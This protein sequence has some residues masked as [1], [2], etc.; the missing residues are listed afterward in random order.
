MAMLVGVLMIHGVQPGPLMM[1]KTPELFWGV[2]TSMY[3]GNF[4]LLVLNL[5][6]I[7]LWVR[8]LLIPY[9]ILFPLILMFC[10]IG[11]YSLNNRI[12]E[13]YL[14][15]GFGVGGYLLKKLA[16]DPTPLILAF[17]LGPMVEDKF[18]HSLLIFDGD[19][20]VFI[21]RPI[22]V[23]FLTAALLLVFLQLIPSLRRK[24]SAALR[25]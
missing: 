13:I 25:E 11:T 10:I 7:G 22:A 23:T 12:F 19:L 5:P 14:M 15:V 6:L 17:V 9:G 4:L 20:S 24:K 21:R 16:Y 2:I 1:S 18:K 3:L 8:M